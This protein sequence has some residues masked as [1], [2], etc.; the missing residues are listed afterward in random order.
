M[1]EP[2]P[3][4][5]TL[6]PAAKDGQD[7]GEEAWHVRYTN[8]FGREHVKLMSREIVGSFRSLN[9][10]L[11]LYGIHSKTLEPKNQKTQQRQ[12]KNN[13]Q[14]NKTQQQQQ[15]Q[16][17]EEQE[18]EAKHRKIPERLGNIRNVPF[19]WYRRWVQNPCKINRRPNKRAHFY[20]VSGFLTQ[21]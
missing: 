13:N 10:T 2:V 15:Q 3:V 18:Q 1:A 14:K 4:V 6:K 16:Q 17:Q 19:K 5:V 20:S 12:T 21:S 7:G 11:A 9:K 8:P